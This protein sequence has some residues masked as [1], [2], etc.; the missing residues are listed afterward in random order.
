MISPGYLVDTSAL[1]RLFSSRAVRARWEQQIGAGVMYV[2]PVTEL[3]F[4]YSARSAAHRR[5]LLDE[6]TT[7]FSWTAVPDRAFAVA[8]STQSALT[9]R[10]MHRSAGAV[11]LLVAATAI[12]QGL[13]I[14]HYDRD[15]EQVAK[16][17]GQRA[18][19]VAPAGS[20]D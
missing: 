12:V 20:V 3:E 15:F 4:L 16:V 14:L 11:D 6:L 13:T 7:A 5:A 2:C 10:G 1:A 8:T 17:S 9:N 18:E 19:W